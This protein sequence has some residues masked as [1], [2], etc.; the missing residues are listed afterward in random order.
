MRY[1]VRYHDCH[2]KAPHLTS[3]SP[4]KAKARKRISAPLES[5]MTTIR[6]TGR[7][8]LNASIRF[9]RRHRRRDGERQIEKLVPQPHD[10]VALGLWTRNDAPIKS[11]TKSTSDPAR[12][13]AEAGSTSTTADSRSITTSSSAR[14]WSISN[15]YWKPE[16]PPP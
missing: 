8:T 2:R 6:R 13:G 4:G 12:K 16:Q 5:A 7:M 11:S 14:A 9:P 1:H 15:L 3:S 10:A